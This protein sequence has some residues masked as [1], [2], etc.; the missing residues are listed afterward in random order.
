MR[1]LV[2]LGDG[3][4][5]AEPV[6]WHAGS[7][8]GLM[9]NNLPANLDQPS[10]YLNLQDKNVDWAYYYGNIA[11]VAAINNLGDLSKKVKRFSQFFKD[12]KAGMLPPVTYIDPR[13]R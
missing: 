5:L 10:I 4:D 7:S 2:L 13:S 6:Y 12:A 1:S 8:F 9:D 3:P 11:V